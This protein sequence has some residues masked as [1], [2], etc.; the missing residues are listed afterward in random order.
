MVRVRE[1]ENGG[2]LESIP[3]LV[4]RVSYNPGGG[5]GPC[6]VSFAA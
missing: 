2:G 1:R 4:K 5:K 3:E 6:G